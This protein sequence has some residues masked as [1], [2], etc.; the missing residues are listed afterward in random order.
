MR[1]AL[2]SDIHG[3]LEAFEAVLSDI[4]KEG[5]DK[6]LCIGDIVGYGADPEKVLT[7]LQSLAPE[8]IVVGNHDWGVA[9]LMDPDYFNKEAKEAVLWTRKMLDRSAID[10]LGSLDL[11][12]EKGDITL[13]HGS[14]ETPEEFYYIMDEGDAYP[15]SQLSRTRLCFVGHSHMPGIYYTEGAAMKRAKRG[16]VKMGPDKKYVINIGS[17]GQPRDGDP[18]AGYSIYD[19]S[20][21]TVEIRRIAYDVESA[22]DKILKA[23]LP[24]FLAH[25]L[26]EGR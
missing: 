23:G 2:I 10:Y 12:Y 11:I 22:K 15:T 24:A 13:V 21:N 25:R 18:K 5:V 7:I 20:E 16:K 3:N 6:Y 1:Y 17:I 9:Q 19:S 14:L 26:L 8:A 4:K